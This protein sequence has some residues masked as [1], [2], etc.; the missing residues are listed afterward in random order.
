[1]ANK[2][3]ITGGTGT[4]GSVL[5]EKLAATDANVRALVRSQGKAERIEASGIEAVIGDLDK[6]ETLPAAL[7]GVG[8]VFLLTSPTERQAEL[9]GNV[10]AAAQNAGVS[11]IVKLSAIGAGPDAP[12]LIRDHYLIEQEIERKGIP[13]THLRPNGFMQNILMNAP[14][15]KEKGLFYGS[16]GE[17]KVS[18]VDARDIAA[19][20]AAVL[21]G[22]GHE[23][24]AYEI[25]GPQ[26]LSSKEVAQEFSSVLGKDVQYVDLPLEAMR[27]SMLGTGMSAWLTDRLIGLFEFYREGRAATVSNVVREVTGQEPITLRQFVREHVEAFE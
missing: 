9:E 2:I 3:L 13:H 15:I 1:M 8:K 5:L 4:V 16:L 11:H 22:D 12:P 7:N 18:Y 10:I 27:S 17:A 6:P 14:T 25:T 19:V 26:S 21:T 24:K 20:A 23:G